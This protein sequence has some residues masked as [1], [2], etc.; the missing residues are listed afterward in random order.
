MNLGILLLS[1][2]LRIS[3]I[4]ATVC[5]TKKILETV[6]FDSFKEV[7][8]ADTVS[9]NDPVEIQKVLTNFVFLGN[10]L[11]FGINELVQKSYDNDNTNTVFDED[12]FIEKAKDAL[13]CAALKVSRS[14]IIS[15][16]NDK[17]T[18]VMTQIK[19]YAP[20][21]IAANKLL[22]QSGIKPYDLSTL[23]LKEFNLPND[24]STDNEDWASM[25]VD[26]VCALTDYISLV[27]N[28]ANELSDKLAHVID[29]VATQNI[30]REA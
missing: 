18:E 7:N 3:G 4:V 26:S 11:I 9:S 24:N 19:E 22:K 2:L 5:L 27:S 16:I 29:K 14:T 25:C 21:F 17:K 6:N 20:A 15:E 28:A 8:I 10:K 23:T 30:A 13:A 1:N 12:N